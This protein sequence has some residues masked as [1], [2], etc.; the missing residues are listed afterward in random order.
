MNSVLRK[1]LFKFQLNKITVRVLLEAYSCIFCVFHRWRIWRGQPSR[2]GEFA[3]TCDHFG[4]YILHR[5]GLCLR[6]YNSHS[7]R[8]HSLLC[9]QQQSKKTRGNVTVSKAFL[10]QYDIPLL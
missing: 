1:H 3:A 8:G 5:R 4:Q 7:H 9:S 6:T 10:Y 2:G